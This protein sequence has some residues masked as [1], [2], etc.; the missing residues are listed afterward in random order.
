MG[1][2][3]CRIVQGAAGPKFTLLELLGVVLYHTL[4]TLKPRL[5]SRIVHT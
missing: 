1:T 4:Q 3:F 2:E 5:P